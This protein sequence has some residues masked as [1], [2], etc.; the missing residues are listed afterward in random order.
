[1]PWAT[2][3]PW[4]MWIAV[5]AALCALALVVGLARLPAR[6]AG[7]R[8]P[9]IAATGLACLVAIAFLFVATSAQ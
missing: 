5:A 1:M 8:E 2:G 4:A 7:L 6:L 3:M 9:L